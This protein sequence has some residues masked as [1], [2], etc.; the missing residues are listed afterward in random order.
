MYYTV[1]Y[2]GLRMVVS[3][4]VLFDPLVYC[5]QVCAWWWAKVYCLTPLCSLQVCTWWWAKVYC[6]TP[7][8]WGHVQLNFSP[9]PITQAVVVLHQLNLYFWILHR[10]T[11]KWC[12]EKNFEILMSTEKS[13]IEGCKNMCFCPFI[14]YFMKEERL[15]QERDLI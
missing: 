15:I 12:E 13:M 3:K 1:H 9:R 2:T 6:L 5:V 11:N 7:P 10:F 8:H 4:N 14:S